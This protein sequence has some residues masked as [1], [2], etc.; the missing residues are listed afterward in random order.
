MRG[1]P[2]RCA[3]RAVIRGRLRA[4]VLRE[5]LGVAV[6]SRESAGAAIDVWFHPA[7]GDSHLCFRES[8]ASGLAELARVFV[9]DPPGHGASPA[10]PQG[11]TIEG[12]AR[13]WRDLVARLSAGRAVVLVGHSMAGIIATSTAQLMR[14]SPVLVVSIE[15]NLTRQDAYFT[16]LAAQ[17]DRP[18]AFHAAFRSSI[19]RRA[20]RDETM[21]R[22]VSSLEFADPLTLWTLGRSVHDYD[23]P[24]AGFRR[25]EC[26]KI[27]YWDAAT[28]SKSAQL[29]L[30]RHRIPQRRLDGLGHWP[31]V[32]SPHT[33]YAAVEQDICDLRPR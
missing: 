24:G 3:T 22:F 20:R 8:F 2:Q 6:Y 28:T 19:L 5:H 10:L 17:F 16:G 29:Y 33:F 1:A 7:F 15:G 32:K 9:F 31:M 27:H 25:L 11:L 30:T 18:Q 13:L 14:H 23:D 21:R 12:A 4:P 26:P